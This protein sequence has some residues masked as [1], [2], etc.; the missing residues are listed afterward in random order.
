MCRA[1]AGRGRAEGGGR[2][3]ESDQEVAH[4]RDPCARPAGRWLM[5]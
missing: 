4:L 2:E 5:S 1:C 3:E